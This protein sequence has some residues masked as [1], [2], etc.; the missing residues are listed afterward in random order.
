M[1]E[2]AEQLGDRTPEYMRGFCKL[3]HGV[4]ILVAENE[5]FA[6]AWETVKP[7]TYETKIALMMEPLDMPVT[8]AMTTKQKKQYLDA[9]YDQ[10]TEMGLQLTVPDDMGLAA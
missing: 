3:S 8:R 6:E 2:I 1:N 9:V 4:P 5:A 10:F 7:L